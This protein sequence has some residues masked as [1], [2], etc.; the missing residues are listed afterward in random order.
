MS[1]P[2]ICLMTALPALQAPAP[3]HDAQAILDAARAKAK[4]VGEARAAHMQAGKNTK[5]FRGDCT[6]ELTELEARLASEKRPDVRQA[7]LVSKLYHLQLAKL[8][9]SNAFLEQVRK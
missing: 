8:D 1:L 3:A 5:D 2:L 9:R 4:S 7:L 6:K